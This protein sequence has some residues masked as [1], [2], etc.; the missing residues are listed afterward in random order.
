MASYIPLLLDA[1]SRLEVENADHGYPGQ[2]YIARGMAAALLFIIFGP[3][4]FKEHIE[5][6]A[7]PDPWM[8]N[9]AQAWLVAHPVPPPDLREY[10]HSNRV[11]RLG[12]ACFT[13]VNNRLDGFETLRQRFFTRRDT[14]ASFAE[15]EI[16][17]LLIYNGCSVRVVGESG[18]R[19][20]DFDLAAIVRGA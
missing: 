10:I 14:R 12:D 13:L 7:N 19:G 11:T 16:A 6:C 2:G 3:D 4:W 18:V 20:Q 8:L 9:C 15:A 5:V 1:L 17:S